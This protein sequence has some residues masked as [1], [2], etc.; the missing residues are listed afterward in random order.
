MSEQENTE[1]VKQAYRNFQTGDIQ[2]LLNLLSEDVAWQLPEIEGVPFAGKRQG[3]EEVAQ[4]FASLAEAQE[5]LQFEPREFVA[6]KDKVVALGRYSWRVKGT[7]REY[8]SEWVHVFTLQGGKISGFHEYMDTASARAAYQKA[9][10][11]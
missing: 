10:A 9:S 6:Q 4:F 1:M 11:A 7:G 5:T 3:R 8:G 2:A